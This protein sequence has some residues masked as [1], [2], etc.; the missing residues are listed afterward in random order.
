MTTTNLQDMFDDSINRNFVVQKISD[1]QKQKMS[2]SHIGKKKSA[3]TKRKMSIAAKKRF[4][5]NKHNRKGAS[6]T[7]EARAKMRKAKLGKPM[8]EAAKQAM[9]DGW[10][11]RKALGLKRKRS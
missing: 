11:R 7:L 2:K 1:Q 10:A 4:A 8:S 6:Q 3:T 5:T 9:R